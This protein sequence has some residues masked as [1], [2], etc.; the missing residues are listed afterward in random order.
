MPKFQKNF[1]KNA[2]SYFNPVSD[3]DFKR[4]HPIGYV[5]LVC[6]GIGGLVLPLVILIL[7]TSVFFPAPNSGFLV[8]A[9]VGCFIMG[10]GI[11][12]IVAAWIG[13]YLGHWVTAVCFL[14]GGLLVAVSC[15]IIYVPDIYSRFD[16]EMVSYYFSSLL[17]LALPPIFYAMFRFAIDSWLRR[18]KISR[19]KIKKLKTG[20]ANYWWYEAI[21]QQYNMGLLYYLNKLLTVSYPITLGLSVLLGWLRPA[22]LLIS[23]LY[24]IVSLAVAAMS[25]FTSVQNNLEEYG[26]PIVIL[27][28][29]KSK[30]IDSIF[31]D[32]AIAVFPLAAAYAHLLM[33]SRILFQ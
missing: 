13:Q 19:S 27:A 23:G 11:F 18:K 30:R 7:V 20:K 6:C 31:F 14:L 12:N 22:T 32:L 5:V 1:P 29:S 10:I 33:M 25:L 24:A 21:H 9:M 2:G 3:E 8:L 28:Q 26:V 16:E 15:V 4:K 17:L